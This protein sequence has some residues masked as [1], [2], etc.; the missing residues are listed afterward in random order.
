MVRETRPTV[1]K[2]R[3]RPTSDSLV[4]NLCTFVSSCGQACERAPEHQAAE[5]RTHSSYTV[6]FSFR[7]CLTIAAVPRTATA[8][9]A[10]VIAASL[11]ARRPTTAWCCGRDPDDA[12]DLG[13]ARSHQIVDTAEV[14]ATVTQYDENAVQCRCGKTHVAEPPAGAASPGR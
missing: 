6:L 4:A 9:P 1:K 10:A 8:A 3:S 7:T 2:P 11:R 12:L 13:S 5:S 14:T